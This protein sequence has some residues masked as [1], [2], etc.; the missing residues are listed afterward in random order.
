MQPESTRIGP[1]VPKLVMCLFS[2]AEK[3]AVFLTSGSLETRKAPC[4][5]FLLVFH[6]HYPVRLRGGL[7]AQTA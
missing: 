2:R 1:G 7:A 6:D 3:I 4:A 5:P